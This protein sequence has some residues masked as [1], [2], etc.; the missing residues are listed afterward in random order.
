VTEL[1]IKIIVSDVLNKFP[2]VQWDR[3]SGELISD[4]GIGVF[5]VDRATRW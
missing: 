2:E 1:A 3:W 5:R 4:A